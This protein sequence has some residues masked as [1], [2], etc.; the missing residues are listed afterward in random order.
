M[1][2]FRDTQDDPSSKE[3]KKRFLNNLKLSFYGFVDL[4]ALH[5]RQ[6]GFLHHDW[7]NFYWIRK[8]KPT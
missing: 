1:Q 7:K 2:L 4:L 8:I 3:R 5:V 6:F